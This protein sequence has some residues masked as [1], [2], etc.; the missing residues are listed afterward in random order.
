[1]S[2]LF[3]TAIATSNHKK[4]HERRRKQLP[5]LR[6]IAG[7]PRQN[8]RRRFGGADPEIFHHRL[9]KMRF[10]LLGGEGGFQTLE[11]KRHARMLGSSGF[12]SVGFSDYTE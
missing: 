7:N 10:V 5:D 1:M 6:M 12:E 3:G 4:I 2:Y 9:S 8:E 11:Q